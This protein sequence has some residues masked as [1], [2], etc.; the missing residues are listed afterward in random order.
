MWS[1]SDLKQVVMTDEESTVDQR[2]LDELASEAVDQKSN[3]IKTPDQ[4]V[5]DIVLEVLRKSQLEEFI[6]TFFFVFKVRRFDDFSHVRDKDMQVIGIQKPQIKHLREQILKISREMWNRSAPKQVYIGLDQ[7]KRN[8]Q[9][10]AFISEK[11]AQ[12]SSEAGA[13]VHPK[14]DEQVVFRNTGQDCFGQ[15]DKNEQLGKLSKA[16]I[17]TA[18]AASSQKIPTEDELMEEKYW[19]IFINWGRSETTEEKQSLANNTTPELQ[20]SIISVE[21]ALS[22][23]AVTDQQ[24]TAEKTLVDE[25][26]GTLSQGQMSYGNEYSGVSSTTQIGAK[27]P[28]SQTALQ[29]QKVKQPVV[30]QQPVVQKP[31]QDQP[32]PTKPAPTQAKQIA[33]TLPILTTAPSTMTS[34]SARALSAPVIENRKVSA[35]APIAPTTTTATT[36]ASSVVTRRPNQTIT[37]S[38]EE[39]RSRI[40]QDVASALPA[41]SALLLGSNSTSA[42]PSTTIQTAGKDRPVAAH[43]KLS[44]TQPTMPPK[45]T[46][47]PILSSEVLQ[48]TPL[49]SAAPAPKP[50]SQRVPVQQP[51]QNPS[52][53]VVQTGLVDKK[54][55][56]PL[57][58]STNV[59]LFNITNLSLY[60]LNSFLNHGSFYQPYAYKM[61]R[62]LGHSGNQRYTSY[63][64]GMGQL[65]PTNQTL[66][67]LLPSENRFSGSAEPLDQSAVNKLPG[68]Q[69]RQKQFR[70]N[71][72]KTASVLL[73]SSPSFADNLSG[74]EKCDIIIAQCKNDHKLANKIIDI[75]RTSFLYSEIEGDAQQEIHHRQ[76]TLEA[77]VQYLGH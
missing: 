9:S 72:A 30:P 36:S 45:K 48:P 57:A 15:Q 5:D 2:A 60:H 27:M 69:N 73:S 25:L 40:I 43:D 32:V 46:S 39:R 4:Y 11:V 31:I 75:V 37:M 22:G 18:P 38:E 3:M 65:A 67:P 21:D 63:P 24:S 51:V 10:S 28:L 53:P 19:D 49:P 7:W 66:A 77:V 17:A 55:A 33:R 76:K 64:S 71:L 29:P 42:L 13:R 34:T 54:P 62:N 61:K 52:P 14:G 70:V 68:A 58:Q 20:S 12:D 59:P 23:E 26:G 1:P 44:Q 6:D 41:P 74:S 8:H 47:E 50:V 35:P 16:V 56:I